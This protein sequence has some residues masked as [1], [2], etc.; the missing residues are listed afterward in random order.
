MKASQQFLD[1]TLDLYYGYLVPKALDRFPAGVNAGAPF[2]A[3]MLAELIRIKDNYF[4]G[5]S[6][7][8][9]QWYQSILPLTFLLVG[10]HPNFNFAQI[11]LH[12]ASVIFSYVAVIHA[13]AGLIRLFPR[14]RFVRAILT[15]LD[16][17]P[18]EPAGLFSFPPCRP[19]DG[20]VSNLP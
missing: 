17:I 1:E 14:G 10:I 20:G 2:F 8:E 11:A 4:A 12:P 9:G 7:A 3:E 19:E 18:Y 5:E 15:L 6:V 13:V 16:S